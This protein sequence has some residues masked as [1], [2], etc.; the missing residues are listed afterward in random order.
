MVQ[1]IPKSPLSLMDP[2]GLPFPP[3]PSKQSSSSV[4]AGSVTLLDSSSSVDSAYWASGLPA[5]SSTLVCCSPGSASDLGP[6]ASRLHL[7]SLFPWLHLRLLC[8]W[9]YRAP[10]CCSTFV[11]HRS[12]SA[13]DVRAFGCAS[14]LHPFGSIRLLL[15]SGST[16]VLTP[17]GSTSVLEHPGSTSAAHH[18]GSALV[19]WSSWSPYLLASPLLAGLMAQPWLLLHWFRP[20]SPSSWASGSLWAL[21]HC[22]LPCGLFCLSLLIRGPVYASGA[23][24]CRGE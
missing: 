11:R 5:P 7:G 15:P 3:P 19:S 20:G 9:F 13:M 17:T 12:T 10:C 8:F 16:S 4:S 6:L 14:F 21:V 23:T 2:P 1:A 18:S 22:Q 24:F